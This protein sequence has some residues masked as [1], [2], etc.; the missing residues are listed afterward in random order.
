MLVI[1]RESVELFEILLENGTVSKL[2]EVQVHERLFVGPPFK[3]HLAKYP[4]PLVRKF[5]KTITVQF[6]FGE[7]GKSGCDT[8]EIRAR[9]FMP[10]HVQ[11]L[12]SLGDHSILLILY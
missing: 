5:F 12:S 4:L 1:D 8:K 11:N 9:H 3:S 6:D 7:S 10:N 2:L